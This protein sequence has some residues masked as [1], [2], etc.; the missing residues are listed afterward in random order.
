MEND[1]LLENYPDKIQALI[2]RRD[3][4]ERNALPSFINNMALE[5][6]F[7]DIK[8]WR[9]GTLKISFKGGTEDLHQKISEIASTW[10]SYGNLNFDFIDASTGKPRLWR[11]DDDSHIRVGFEYRGYWS[12]VGTDSRDPRIVKPGDITLNLGGFDDGKPIDDDRQ[13]TILHEFGH[14]IGFHHEHQTQALECDFDWPKLYRTLA[15]PPN[16]WSKNK[17]DHNL[18]QLTIGGL[19]YTAHDKHSIMHY[20]FP[21]WMFLSGEKSSCYTSRNNQ[22]SETDK[23]MM[24]RAYP[25]NLAIAVNHA[26]N[27]A[28]NLETILVEGD[29]L[30]TLG[31]SFHKTHFDFL[32]V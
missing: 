18:K 4:E 15:G 26:A 11:H 12:L 8:L 13:G 9:N 31:K 28:R 17:V 32:S 16:F 21:Q 22:L 10:C 5:L 23:A 2:E 1:L 30:S 20:S 27:R 25:E 3:R 19:Q 6:V 24:R 29:R 7:E 14:A